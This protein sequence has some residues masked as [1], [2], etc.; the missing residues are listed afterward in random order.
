MRKE[1]GIGKV[2][3]DENGLQ[4]DILKT[5]QPNGFS[6]FLSILGLHV[7]S[8]KI[9]YKTKEPFDFFILI[10]YKRF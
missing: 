1:Q 6:K 2:Q 9:K 10:S 4:L 8:Q 7:T 5:G 3:E